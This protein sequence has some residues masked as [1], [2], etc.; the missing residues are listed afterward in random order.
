M[1]K[2]TKPRTEFILLLRS[3]GLY[4]LFKVGKVDLNILVDDCNV[5]NVV[6]LTDCE[7][8]SLLLL[9]RNSHE[10]LTFGGSRKREE[11]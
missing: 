7:R 3:C 11:S 1:I 9:N 6:K 10:H 2:S 4:I 8:M 5:V